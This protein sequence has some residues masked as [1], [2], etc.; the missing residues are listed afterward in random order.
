MLFFTKNIIT[1][2]I[3]KIESFECEEKLKE[4]IRFIDGVINVKINRNKNKLI[5]KVIDCKK[6]YLVTIEKA[7]SSAECKFLEV[8]NY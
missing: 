3:E 6:M 2:K 1:A 5:I 4:T 7:I 8:K